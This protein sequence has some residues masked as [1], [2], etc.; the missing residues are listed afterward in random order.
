MERMDKKL[1]VLSSPVFQESER[2]DKEEEKREKK[3]EAEREKKG[4]EE[5]RKEE[6]RIEEERSQKEDKEKVRMGVRGLIT[7]F[8]SRNNGAA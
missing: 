3:E 4:E 7:S 8:F 5:R 6:A 2:L 1:K